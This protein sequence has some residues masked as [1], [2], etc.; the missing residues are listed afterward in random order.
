MSRIHSLRPC[1]RK[2]K[3][4]EK[5]TKPDIFEIHICIKTQQFIPSVHAKMY[6]IVLRDRALTLSTFL[7]ETVCIFIVSFIRAHENKYIP[8]YLILAC[9]EMSFSNTTLSYF[10]S[11]MRVISY[12]YHVSIDV[13][14]KIISPHWAF[15]FLACHTLA[16]ITCRIY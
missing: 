4:S 7:F 15:T 14:C 13:V 12:P 16:I 6:D 9:L 8:W 11:N 1:S 5:S 3:S 10:Y 2:R